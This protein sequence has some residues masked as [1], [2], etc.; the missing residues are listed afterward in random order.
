ML[1]HVKNS[2][3]FSFLWKVPWMPQDA[4]PIL[5]VVSLAGFYFVRPA[6]MFEW[7]WVGYAALTYAAFFVVL[8]WLYYRIVSKEKRA[9]TRVVWVGVISFLGG[10]SVYQLLLYGTELP[11]LIYQAGSALG[12]RDAPTPALSHNWMVSID[13]IVFTV[14]AVGLITSFFGVKSLKYFLGPII[15]S[16]A[17]ICVFLIDAAYP[18]TQFTI[19]QQWVPAIV[20]LVANLLRALRVNV[21]YSK[22]VL[23]TPKSGA[24]VIGWPCA[25]VHSL[26]IYTA[27]A[28]S[29][30][31][32]L[33][34]SR[35]RKLIYLSI[36]FFGTYMTNILR[37][38]VIIF[39]N[40]YFNWDIYMIHYYAGELFF[41]I[42]V[43]AFLF[44][45]VTIERKKKPSKGQPTL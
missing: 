11:Q 6:A 15:Y 33:T 24:I 20:F 3:I 41:I 12:L 28:Y 27:V 23:Y 37:I 5:E 7:M 1:A 45:V 39:G 25:G 40:Y 21:T 17:L 36:G 16:V 34:I 30:L 29:F 14:Y 26:L 10:I 2:R 8:T 18:L 42:W 22:D 19:F 44:M 9:E 35:V 31:Q 4:F 13:F 32:T 38:A 43:V